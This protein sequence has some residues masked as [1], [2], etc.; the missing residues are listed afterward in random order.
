MRLERGSTVIEMTAAGVTIT[1]ADMTLDGDVTVTGDLTT[2]GAL[3][4]QWR[5]SGAKLTGN[6]GA[7]GS[8]DN[9]NNL[10]DD[11]ITAPI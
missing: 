5:P 7:T 4:R 9:N 1:A 2:E 11:I 6:G 3:D 10:I 8:R